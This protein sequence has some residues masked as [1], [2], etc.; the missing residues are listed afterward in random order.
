MR[1]VVVYLYNTLFTRSDDKDRL[2]NFHQVLSILQ[3]AGLK[4]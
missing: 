2:Q 1:H 4:L 3:E